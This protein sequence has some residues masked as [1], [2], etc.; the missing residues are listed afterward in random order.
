MN[1]TAIKNVLEH[2]ELYR[3]LR[4][5]QRY[6]LT[7][8]NRLRMRYAIIA[9][10]FALIV[11]VQLFGSMTSSFALFSSDPV[12]YESQ[13]TFES[14]GEDNVM[15]LASLNGV[16]NS[17]NHASTNH[18]EEKNIASDTLASLVNN[19]GSHVEGIENLDVHEKILK[20]GAGDTISGAMKRA[21]ISGAEAFRAVKAM[22]TYYDPRKIRPGQAIAVK[23]ETSSD[24][25]TLTNLDMKINPTKAL[26]VYK[27]EHERYKA[28]LI[29]KDVLLKVKASRAVID[30][31]LYASA[32]RAGIPASLIA[33]MIRLYSYEIDFQRDIRKGD[34][35]EILYET[36]ET[37]D[38]EFAHYGHLLF[39]SLNVNKTEIPIYRFEQKGKGANYYHKDGASL[40]QLLMKT[41][42]DGAR[43]SSGYGM[44]KHPILGYSKMHKG[45][46]FAAPSGTPIYAAGDGVVERANRFGN[47]GNYIRLRHN[48]TYK[49][50]YAHL[51]K[52]AKGMKTG[53]RVKQGQ[54]IGYVGSTGR[55]TGPHLHYE[56]IKNGKQINPKNVKS[57]NRETLAGDRLKVFKTQIA[58]LKGQYVSL[59]QNLEFAKN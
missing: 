33:E 25:F 4:L 18:A 36:Y 30:D 34:T 31:S 3:Y 28:D 58:N 37:E 21:G 2:I 8:S 53:K 17:D 50:A 9:S 1:F 42:V 49:T 39:A 24:G 11:L 51:R 12:L 44:R 26:Y 23:I 43:I 41:P 19:S 10:F 14:T 40:K 56:V 46:D 32:A 57:A 6:F 20:I 27:D 16:N 7:R 13:T 5:R 38:G 45:I 55:S 54:V 48:S 59:E 29:E 47:Y 35:V 52:F 22:S 15:V